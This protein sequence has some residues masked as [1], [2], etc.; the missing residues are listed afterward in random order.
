M[1]DVNGASVDI[2]GYVVALVEFDGTAVYFIVESLAYLSLIG[3]YIFRP[4]NAMH[5]FDERA[6]L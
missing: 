2:S 3:T 5:T 4:H 6:P 1:V